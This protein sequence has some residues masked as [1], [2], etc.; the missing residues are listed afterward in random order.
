[1]AQTLTADYAATLA[2]ECEPIELSAAPSVQVAAEGL[3]GAD[4][5]LPE[6]SSWAQRATGEAAA[7]AGAPRTVIGRSP[8]VLAY[9]QQVRDAMGAERLAGENLVAMLLEAK[10]YDAHGQPWGT[11]KLVSPDPNTTAVGAVGFMTMAMMLSNGEPPPT[12]PAAATENQR[13]MVAAEHRIVERV[14]T[15]Q[16]VFDKLALNPADDT[17]RGPAGPRTG[18]TTE[19]AA[20]A[21][22]GRGAAIA[23]DYLADGSS[24]VELTIV[25]PESNPVIQDFVDWLTAPEGEQVLVEQGIRVGEAA[26][27]AA[28]LQVGKQNRIIVLTDG[29]DEEHSNVF[30]EQDLLARLPATPD[31]DRPIVISYLAIG[32]DADFDAVK[33]V[34]DATSGNAV[35]VRDVSELPAIMQGL[36]AG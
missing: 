15:S 34:A 9:E 5:W 14:A 1:M 8:L 2:G 26:P 22:A 4:A 29:A 30:T 35:W 7:L 17:V 11:I 25:S 31:P 28:E 6:D 16:S 36:L 32:P 20:L 23:A 21:A 18:V 33:R 24:G 10:R 13:R 12:D 19:Y 27:D 3:A